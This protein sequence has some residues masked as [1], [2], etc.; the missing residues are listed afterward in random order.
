MQMTKPDAN[1]KH[2]DVDSGIL[3]NRP[4]DKASGTYDQTVLADKKQ[5]IDMGIL[6]LNIIAMLG[7]AAASLTAFPACVKVT[8]FAIYLGMLP[9][10]FKRLPDQKHLFD[11]A[12]HEWRSILH[13]VRQ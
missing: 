10:P 3:Q 6:I 5:T 9:P 2:V 7:K 12:Y 8:F 13:D 1:A 4:V 11:A